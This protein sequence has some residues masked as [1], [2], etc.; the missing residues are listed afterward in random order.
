MVLIIIFALVTALTF[1]ILIA[2]MITKNIKRILAFAEGM[3]NGD[4]TTNIHIEGKDEIGMLA[5]NMNIATE[6]T[7][8]L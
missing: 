3:K 7:K 1:G 5:R 6:N 8:K 4:L 2:N